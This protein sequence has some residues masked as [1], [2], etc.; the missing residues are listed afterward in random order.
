MQK[1]KFELDRF[2]RLEKNNVSR[3]IQRGETRDL[4]YYALVILIT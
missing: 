3:S 4:V 1:K 2:Y